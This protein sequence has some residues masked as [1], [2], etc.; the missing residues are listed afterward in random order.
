MTECN[1]YFKIFG[2]VKLHSSV[3]YVVTILIKYMNV[4]YTAGKISIEH[5]TI[6]PCKYIS[7]GAVDMKFSPDVVKIPN[8]TNE[9]RNKV[10]CNQM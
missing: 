4:Q 10:M 3:F 5:L 7:K 1:D 6:F 2:A 9:F 8:K